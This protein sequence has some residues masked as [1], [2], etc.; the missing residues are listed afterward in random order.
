MAVYLDRAVVAASGEHS[1][2]FGFQSVGEVL[3]ILAAREWFGGAARVAWIHIAALAVAASAVPRTA[4]LLGLGARGQMVVGIL[5]ATWLPSAM[6]AQLY[7]GESV[8]TSLTFLAVAGWVAGFSQEEPPAWHQWVAGLALG[9][10]CAFRPNLQITVLVAC[11][12]GLWAGRRRHALTFAFGA[13]LGLAFALAVT[14]A[15]VPEGS[16]LAESGGFNFYMSV[17]PIRQLASTTGGGGWAPVVN[18]ALY[19]RA[20]TT[21]VPLTDSAYFY[22]EAWRL[23]TADPLAALSRWATNLW[24]STGAVMTFPGLQA[25]AGDAALMVWAKVSAVATLLAVVGARR[26]EAPSRALTV[27][28]V[29]SGFVTCAFF[30]GTPRARYPFDAIVLSVGAAQV[31]RLSKNPVLRRRVGQVAPYVARLR[32]IRCQLVRV[33]RD[34]RC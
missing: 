34:R 9:V 22:G 24:C 11:G 16:G 28:V 20:V 17:A 10:G 21:D 12:W 13:G 3:L 30:L 7:L 32:S 19:T 4:A 29:I 6:Y 25:R 2:D 1:R 27:L 31:A 18:A 33:G 23:I 8:A 14:R 5:V 26:A 15:L